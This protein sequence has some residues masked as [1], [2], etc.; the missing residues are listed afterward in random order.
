MACAREAPHTHVHTGTAQAKTHSSS[1]IN[2]RHTL[3]F[4]GG[5]HVNVIETSANSWRSID[6]TP[7]QPAPCLGGAGKPL[8]AR[9][10]PL[11]VFPLILPFPSISSI[12]ALFKPLQLRLAAPHAA[13]FSRKSFVYPSPLMPCAREALHTRVRA[14]THEIV[15]CS[16]F[17][18]KKPYLFRTHSGEDTLALLKPRTLLAQFQQ[19]SK[20]AISV[21]GA[22]WGANIYPPYS[23][24]VAG[25]FFLCPS[26]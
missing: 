22:R 20:P 9:Q 11:K 13:F 2:C 10:P 25:L 14:R 5:G 19:H 17:S 23:P 1:P 24:K 16:L 7:N 4:W 15:H 3:P 21:F 6:D 12:V 26:F 18:P 8:F